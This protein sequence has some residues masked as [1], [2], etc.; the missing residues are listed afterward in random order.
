MFVC[1]GVELAQRYIADAA[2]ERGDGAQ[3][4]GIVV[5]VGKQAQIGQNV[6]DFG[7]VKKALS[8]RE[9]VRNARAA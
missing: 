4:G 6:F 8:A 3:K 7:F 9:L 2:F 1:V 5:G